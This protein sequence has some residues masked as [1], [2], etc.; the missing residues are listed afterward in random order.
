MVTLSMFAQIY[1]VI[2]AMKLVQDSTNY[3]DS[4]SLYKWDFSDGYKTFFVWLLVEAAIPA[5]ALLANALFLT[6][7]G[8]FRQRFILESATCPHHPESDFL[9]A[10]QVEIGLI[11]SW[12]TPLCITSAI[13]AE[14]R[15][16]RFA[17]IDPQP[18][19]LIH[20]LTFLVIF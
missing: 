16:P 3:T 9:A 8:L 13:I 17:K 1:L 2:M 12:V 6:T 11:S 5:S 7:R 10:R 4:F 19:N 14:R 18:E 20:H 15:N